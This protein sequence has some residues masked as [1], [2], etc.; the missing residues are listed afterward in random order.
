MSRTV[1]N[2]ATDDDDDDNGQGASEMVPASNGNGNGLPSFGSSCNQGGRVWTNLRPTSGKLA[3]ALVRA[4]GKADF[5]ADDLPDGKM[6]VCYLMVQEVTLEDV[7][8]GEVMTLPRVV[9]MDKDGKSCQFVSI[10][11]FGSIKILTEIFGNGPWEPGL[12]VKLVRSKTKKGFNIYRL[13]LDPN[14]KMPALQ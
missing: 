14:G 4:S 11:I 2:A 10:G 1:R 9:I 7:Q 5:T 8:S 6:T 12:P 13:E 3:A